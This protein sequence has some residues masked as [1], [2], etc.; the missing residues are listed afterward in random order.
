LDGAF[1]GTSQAVLEDAAEYRNADSQPR[2]R[3]STIVGRHDRPWPDNKG[4]K[5]DQNQS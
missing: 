5:L 3:F 4:G 1:F 2:E